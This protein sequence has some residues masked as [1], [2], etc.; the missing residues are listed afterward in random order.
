MMGEFILGIV[1]IFVFLLVGFGPAV[2]IWESSG[3]LGKLFAIVV[4]IA[5]LMIASWI[6]SV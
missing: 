2:E 1:G 3:P 5:G 4:G 6:I